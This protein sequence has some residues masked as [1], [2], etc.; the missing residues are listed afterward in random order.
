MKG[1]KDFNNYLLNNRLTIFK[2]LYKHR[3]ET[4]QNFNEDMKLLK[5]QIKMENEKEKYENLL[6]KIKEYK[7]S[8][9]VLDGGINSPNSFVLREIKHIPNIYIGVAMMIPASCGTI[10]PMIFTLSLEILTVKSY[11]DDKNKIDNIINK[12]QI[13]RNTLM[14]YPKGGEILENFDKNEIKRLNEMKKYEEYY[15]KL[16]Y[17]NLMLG[18][19]VFL[20]GYYVV[21]LGSLAFIGC[22]LLGGIMRR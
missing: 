13:L 12:E 19:G 2:P 20:S 14:E 11:I 7:K 17:N 16:K 8:L 3:I 6:K 4:M 18:T 21:G 1:L 22:E 5:K 9:K 15:I 10:L